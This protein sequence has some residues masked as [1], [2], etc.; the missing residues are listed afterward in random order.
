MKSHE[1][2]SVHDKSTQNYRQKTSSMISYCHSILALLRTDRPEI[3]A[4]HQ[5]LMWI[6]ALFGSFSNNWARHSSNPHYFNVFV[7]HLENLGF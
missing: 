3:K 7:K 6:N 4:F 2:V 5:N 1:L